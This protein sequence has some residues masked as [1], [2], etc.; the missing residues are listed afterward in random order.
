M[1]Q[2]SQK[3]F[4]NRFDHPNIQYVCSDIMNVDNINDYDVCYSI[5][6]LEHYNDDEI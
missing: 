3:Y 1:I 4:Q 2:L 6:I 5:G